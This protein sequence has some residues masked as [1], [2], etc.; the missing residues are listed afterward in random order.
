MGITSPELSSDMVQSLNRRSTG[1]SF[2]I[3]SYTSVLGMIDWIAEG[4]MT[5]LDLV[6]PVRSIE[7]QG[8]LVI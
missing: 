3:T 7:H 4:W 6:G 1:G 5:N 2:T 8:T